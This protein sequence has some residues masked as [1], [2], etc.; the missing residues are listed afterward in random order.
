M[1]F[2]PNG[3]KQVL[4]SAS[5][6][7]LRQDTV[8]LWAVIVLRVKLDQ[9]FS[10]SAMV[11]LLLLETSHFLLWGAVLGTAGCLTASAH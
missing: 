9:S 5:L 8:L 10:A 1:I 7:D 3:V 4:T 11:T 2:P 6:C